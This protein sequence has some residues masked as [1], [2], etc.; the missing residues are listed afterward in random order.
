M[1]FLTY[2]HWRRHRDG[3]SGVVIRAVVE[4]AGCV[5]L[6]VPPFSSILAENGTL[7][8]NN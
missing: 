1:K 7:D 3:G 6:G 4:S 2:G 5:P 8:R